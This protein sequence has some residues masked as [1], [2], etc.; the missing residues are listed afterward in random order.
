MHWRGDYYSPVSTCALWHLP[1]LAA[2]IGQVTAKSDRR[3]A[4][5]TVQQARLRSHITKHAWLSDQLAS[6]RISTPAYFGKRDLTGKV[7]TLLRQRI[8]PSAGRSQERALDEKVPKASAG[9]VFVDIDEDRNKAAGYY[10]ALRFGADVLDRTS[11]VI[12]K[13]E[14]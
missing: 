5:A 7:V 8:D 13:P 2:T 4:P 11:A 12:R 14:V 1:A 10:A 6:L 9:M 3:I